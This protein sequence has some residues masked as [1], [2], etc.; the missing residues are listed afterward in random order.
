[1]NKHSS[2]L[3][4]IVNYG[5]YKCFRNWALVANFQNYNNLVI[6]IIVERISLTSFSGMFDGLDVGAADLS[7]RH[8]SD[9]F[10]SFLMQLFF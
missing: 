8:K 9:D 10:N 2:I 3:Q 1:M 6:E 7:R 5:H 4:T